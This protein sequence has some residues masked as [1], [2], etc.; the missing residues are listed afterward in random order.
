MIAK[1]PS[2]LT[3]DASRSSVYRHRQDSIKKASISFARLAISLLLMTGFSS[4]CKSSAGVIAPSANFTVGWGVNDAGQLGIGP[5]PVSSP[6]G[7]PFPSPINLPEGRRIIC[8][9]ASTLRTV[10]LADDGTIW[11]WGG[12]GLSGPVPTPVR[13]LPDGRSVMQLATGHLF[14]LALAS[15]GSIWAWGEGPEGQLGNNFAPFEP[16]S[17]DPTRAS[18]PVP[19][20]QLPGGR[21]AVAISAGDSRGIGG[22][23]ALALADDG[24]IWGWGNN[25][26]GQLGNDSFNSSSAPTQVSP[27]PGGRKATAIACGSLHSLAVADDGSIWAWGFNEYGQLGNG[28]SFVRSDAAAQGIHMASP[29]PVPVVGLPGGRKAVSAAAGLVHS[30]ALAEDGTLW[31]WGCVGSSSSTFGDL[32]V[33][34]PLGSML[35][36]NTTPAKVF[37]LPGNRKAVGISANHLNNFAIAEDGTV[38]GWGDAWDGELGDGT[39]YTVSRSLPTQVV[40]LPTGKEVLAVVS[41]GT[42]TFALLYDPQ[43]V[44]LPYITTQP[45]SQVVPIGGSVSFTVVAHGTGSLNY[46]WRRNGENIPDANN[47]TLTLNNVLHSEEGAYYVVVSNA[48]G[49]KTSDSAILSVAIPAPVPPGLVAWWR[50]ESDARD[51][52]ASHDGTVMNGVAFVPGKVGRAFQFSGSAFIEVPDAPELRIVD[53]VT[54]EF[55]AKRPSADSHGI[56]IEKGGDWTQGQTDY[57][58]GLG[59]FFFTYA[60]GYQRADNVVRDTEWHHYAVI[61]RDGAAQPQFYLDGVLQPI[62]SSGGGAIHLS[63]S[64]LPLHI[65]AQVAGPSYFSELIIDELSLYNRAL[66]ADEIQSIFNADSAGKATAPAAPIITWNSPTEIAC[67]T[68]LST[69]QLNATATIPGTFSYTPPYGTILPSGDAQTLS[70]LFT[71][72]NLT[73]YEP[74]CI[75]VLINVVS[76]VSNTTGVAPKTIVAGSSTRTLSVTGSCFPPGAVVLWNGLARSTTYV[77]ETLLKA[78]ISP[79]DIASVAD[80]AL[81]TIA[82]QNPGGAVSN[83]QVLTIANPSIGSLE[84]GLAVAGETITVLDIPLGI[85]RSGISA[86]VHNS[87]GDVLLASVATYA[88]IP[89]SGLIYDVGASYYDVKVS[90]EDENDS[91]D[92]NFYYSSDATGSR[93]NK[94]RLTYFNGIA[95]LPVRN[96]GNS[97]PLKNTEDNLDQTVSGGR[98]RLRFDDTSTPKLSQL[99]STVLAL[100]DTTPEVTVSGPRAPL[101]LGAGASITIQYHAVGTSDGQTVLVAWGDGSTS[102]ATP[103][104]LGTTGAAHIYLTSGVY[105]VRV[106]ILDAN[107]DVGTGEYQYIVVY[108]PSDG[109]VTGGGWITSPSGSFMANPML[110]GKATFGFVSKYQKGANFP[111]GQTQF[112]F[113]DLDFHSTSYEWL[114]VSGAR[115]QCKGSGK[116]NQAGDFGFILTAI[117]GQSTGGGGYDRFRIKIWDKRTGAIAYDNQKDAD[118]TAPL[119]DSTRTGGGSIVIQSATTKK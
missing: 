88:S 91:M 15:D 13:S 30:L 39:L 11:Q 75:S 31:S 117:D 21:K 6:W 90:G 101:A 96:S 80:L 99:H 16:G 36:Q 106:S 20:N 98:F 10:A 115:A 76:P 40:G 48:G 4:P 62:T 52:V 119:N 27:L 100:A 24:S 59:W 110:T 37:D 58:V 82:V 55:W 81:V 93:E 41:G 116:I 83:P 73:N 35:A 64:S 87:G 45:Q 22:G 61:A 113:K 26:N 32:S 85:G 44:Q 84:S 89:P 78:D 49:E 38:W 2:L 47:A 5:V 28:T 8:L 9:A 18:E 118:D 105:A 108:D 109:F 23:H 51:S 57:V 43:A 102:T 71:P 86:T 74:I 53:A 46:Q 60:G 33:Y 17:F 97:N 56:V 112:Q 67:G 65:G 72:D 1:P 92:V 12:G 104:A 66:T 114:V 25:L 103:S 107:G 95:W 77:D 7:T 54:I 3:K 70:A 94:L 29:V 14:S 79:A 63:S 69:S 34:T 68:P 111:T 19:V 42:T 50:G